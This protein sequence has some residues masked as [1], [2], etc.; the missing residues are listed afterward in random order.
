MDF[1]GAA[2]LAVG[3]PAQV[4]KFVENKLI[5]FM[6]FMGIHGRTSNK[7]GIIVCSLQHQKR[8]HLKG[9]YTLLLLHLFPIDWLSQFIIFNY[10]V[11]FY[12]LSCF[13]TSNL[14][15]IFLS[16][17]SIFLDYFL[18]IFRVARLFF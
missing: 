4:C 9:Q 11:N 15:L 6:R 14:Q 2:N 8:I 12:L 5:C 7:R 16:I 3:M 18:S 10:L 17:A 1:V 13:F